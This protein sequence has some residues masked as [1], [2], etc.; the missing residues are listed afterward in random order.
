MRL[1]S[2]TFDELTSR[3]VSRPF[4]GVLSDPESYHPDLSILV[5]K[6]DW[7]YYVPEGV[8]DVTPLWDTNA[9]SCVRW[10]RNGFTE[11]V[12]LF[13]DDANWLLIATSEQGIMAKLWQEW[14]EFQDSDA[15]CR[16]FAEAIG[17]RDWEVGLALLD[18]NFDAFKKWMVEL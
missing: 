3:G 6:T 10:N 11:Y 5:G 14:V 16:R 2:L 12:R 1:G 15:E 8:T 13:H 17:F 9:D 18:A 4:A 7:D